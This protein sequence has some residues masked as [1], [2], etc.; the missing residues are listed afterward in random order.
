MR[1]HLARGVTATKARFSSGPL[2]FPQQ[3]PCAS[4]AKQPNSSP[5]S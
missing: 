4:F 3:A 5:L 2:A 1:H